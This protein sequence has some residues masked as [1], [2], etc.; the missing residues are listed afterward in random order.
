MH[1][2]RVNAMSGVAGVAQVEKIDVPVLMQ[3]GKEDA[4][5]GFSDPEV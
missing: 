3:F 4:I 1:S 2:R 5:T